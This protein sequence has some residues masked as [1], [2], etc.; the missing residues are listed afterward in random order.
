MKVIEGMDGHFFDT[1]HNRRV[2]GERPKEDI[3]DFIVQ[4]LVKFSV[5]GFVDD[6]VG[7]E[8]GFAQKRIDFFAFVADIVA[9]APRMKERIDGGKII[10]V[11]DMQRHIETSFGED[12]SR[13]CGIVEPDQFDIDADL[14]QFALDAQDEGLIRVFAF[15][16]NHANLE[17]FSA[18]FTKLSR[19]FPAST[20]QQLTRFVGVLA[21]C[22]DRKVVEGIVGRKRPADDLSIAEVGAAQGLAIQR[23]DKGFTDIS[24]AK[25]AFVV[26]ADVPPVVGG[27]GIQA[28]VLIAFKGGEIFGANADDR[29]DP[30]V[31]EDFDLDVFVRDDL[32]GGTGQ[33]GLFGSPV[34]VV[35]SED[36]LSSIPFVESKR[37]GAVGFLAKVIGAGDHTTFEAVFGD[38]L[39]LKPAFGLAEG[40]FEV[41]ADGVGIRDRDFFDDLG[42]VTVGDLGSLVGHH[43][44]G[45]FDILGGKGFAIVPFHALSEGEG[46]GFFVFADHP[47]GGE[48]R[49][50]F[51]HFVKTNQAFKD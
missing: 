31:A 35:S 48:H 16:E 33:T 50:R 10:K 5:D 8:G 20:I 4:E 39:E 26:E 23:V 45:E 46:N 36:N 28:N 14:A 41:D 13:P 3:G 27:V 43:L 25:D 30:T 49:R 24:V 2:V 18:F 42:Q 17:G 9:R 38:D 15:G 44:D 22:G 12:L 6:G 21:P 19:L 11:P 47:F 1:R 40:F 37:A 29:I 7:G 51:L 32:E 34:A